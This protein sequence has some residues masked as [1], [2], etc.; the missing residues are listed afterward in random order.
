MLC[1]STFLASW[2]PFLAGEGAGTC[3]GHD[4]KMP[5]EQ[6]NSLNPALPTLKVPAFSLV[7]GQKS[8]QG[9]L[10]PEGDE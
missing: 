3:W 1:G 4:L 5:P 9:P 6:R 8:S 10:M 7:A 2:V